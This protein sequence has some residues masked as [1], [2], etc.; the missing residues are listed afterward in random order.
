MHRS[1]LRIRYPRSRP[2]HMHRRALDLVL[3][4]QKLITRKVQHEG[5]FVVEKRT[6]IANPEHQRTGR[7]LRVRY[8][9][10]NLGC[11]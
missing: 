5:D 9:D 2:R 6:K 10:A 11:S 4:F 7:S 3:A 8:L 1:L